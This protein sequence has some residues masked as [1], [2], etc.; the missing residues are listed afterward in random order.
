MKILELSFDDVTLSTIIDLPKHRFKVGGVHYAAT[1]MMYLNETAL[2][3][4][5]MIVNGVVAD[6]KDEIQFFADKNI[7]DDK[8]DIVNSILM[9]IGYS[10]RKCGRNGF[11]SNSTFLVH[12]IKIEEKENGRIVTY[13]LIKEHAKAIHD[14]AQE[15]EGPLNFF[16]LV[17]AVEQK[18]REEMLKHIEDDN[19]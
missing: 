11:S 8:L 3:V 6:P 10:A 2:G 16:K 4:F 9:A 7:S 12:G 13:H 5:S 14:Y 17:V 18:S 1:D 15:H 19:K